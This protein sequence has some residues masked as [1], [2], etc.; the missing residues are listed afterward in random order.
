[1][2]EHDLGVPIAALVAE[3]FDGA[4]FDAPERERILA[5]VRHGALALHNATT[6]ERVPLLPLWRALGKI[7]WLARARQLPKTLLAL[8]A[9]AAAVAALVFIPADFDISARGELQPEFRRE[10]FARS[11]GVI[12]EIRVKHG[13]LVQDGAILA[14][15]R[16]PQLAFE[17]SRL[18]GEIT[19]AQSRLDSIR[20]ARLSAGENPSDKQ[21]DKLNQLAAEEEEVKALLA[22]LMRQEQILKLQE[23]DLAL[24]SPMAGT[25]IT[26]N[27]EELLAA[28]PVARGQD[29]L[30][31]A[32][33]NG[34]WVV[35]VQVPDHRIGH[36]LAAQEQQR[37]RQESTELPTSFVLATEPGARHDGKVER[38][39]LTAEND[40]TSGSTVLVTVAI[41]RT[42]IPVDQLRP[43][44]TAVVKI[45]CGRRSLGYVWLHELWET[46]QSR[47][48]F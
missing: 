44:A 29:L 18:A 32:D 9:I 48:L 47:V 34:P 5:V 43:G 36:V 12:D 6:Y 3:R 39:A 25:V 45:H 4:P 2:D 33:L 8:A 42:V 23:S 19:T 31:V 16:K 38:I 7:G 24:R 28:R 37:A 35:Q 26:W 41:D 30:T 17:S 11:D 21:N 40:K 15:L 46:I 14:T 22:G 27:I 13:E 20:A 1:M 10:V